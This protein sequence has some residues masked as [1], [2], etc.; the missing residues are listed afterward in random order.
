MSESEIRDFAHKLQ[1]FEATLTRQQRDVLIAALTRA[2][3]DDVEDVEGHGVAGVS[4]AAL[5]LML[6]N[7]AGPAGLNVA[8]AHPAAHSAP[9]HRVVS[10]VEDDK[11]GSETITY[12]SGAGPNSH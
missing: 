4:F 10:V 8:S 2:H 5:V 7:A 9:P 6:A 11:G 3:E 12:E 1:A